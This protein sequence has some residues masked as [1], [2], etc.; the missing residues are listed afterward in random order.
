MW[1]S[2]PVKTLLG[3]GQS[4]LRAPCA[5]RAP[6]CDELLHLLVSPQFAPAGGLRS[7]I[8]QIHLRGCAAQ[9]DESGHPGGDQSCVCKKPRPVPRRHWKQRPVPRRHWN[10]DQSPGDTGIKTSPQETLETVII[11][12]RHW[13]QRPLPGDTGN[14]DHYQETLV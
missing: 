4:L 9:R 5:L 6:D 12:R 14:R 1:L 10:K 13:K 2:R 11:T 7:L 3:A 8:H